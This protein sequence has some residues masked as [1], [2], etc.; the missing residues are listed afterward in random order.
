[1]RPGK[2]FNKSA[3]GYCHGHGIIHRDLKPDNIMIDKNK[4][5]K[6]IDF[7]LS[8]QFQPGQLLSQ[9]CGAYSFGAPELFLGHLYDGPKND[10]WTIGVVLYYMVVGEL[11]FDSVNRQELQRQ[12]VA[13]V[14]PPRCGV[15]EELQDLLSL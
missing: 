14:Y 2:N 4:N 10:M 6:V 13:G 12:V 3:V 1:M 7:G 9:H 8:I 5:V 11:P 15:S